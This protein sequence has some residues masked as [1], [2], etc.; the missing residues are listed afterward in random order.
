M[1][2]DPLG[3]CGLW[4][5]LISFPAHKHSPPYK[6]NPVWN[7]ATGWENNAWET[8]WVRDGDN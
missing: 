6:K 8:T 4:L 1:P 7:P 2:P 5:Q 3:G